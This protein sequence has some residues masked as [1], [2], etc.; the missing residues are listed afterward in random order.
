MANRLTSRGVLTGVVTVLI[1]IALASGIARSFYPTTVVTMAESIRARAWRALDIH[2]PSPAARSRKIGE[3]ESRFAANVAW[4]VVHAAVGSLFL[5][6]AALQ[7]VRPLRRRHLHLHRWN[8]RLLIASGIAIAL[9]GMFF[10]VLI[11]AAG[12]REAVIIGMAGT[13]FVVSLVNGARAIYRRD[14][15]RHGEWMTR[16][17]ASAI[18]VSTVRL[19]AAVADLTLTPR[20]WALEDIFILSLALGWGLT[21]GVT[22]IAIV[23]RKRAQD[24]RVRGPR[25]EFSQGVS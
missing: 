8:G 15:R 9:T 24:S 22:E 3:V 16:A 2:D 20:G 18:G 21:I 10:G 13:Y 17:F 25:G 19:V 6:L 1:A 7:F 5:L 23:V 12:I 14:M 4:I 11:P